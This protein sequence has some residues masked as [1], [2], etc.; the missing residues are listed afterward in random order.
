MYDG[1]AQEYV[2]LIMALV[3]E[4]HARRHVYADEWIQIP[5]SALH[6]TCWQLYQ[7][8]VPALY[9]RSNFYLSQRNN[10]HCTEYRCKSHHSWSHT[11]ASLGLSP[12]FYARF[13]TQVTLHAVL[14]TDSQSEFEL[15]SDNEELEAE[16][17]HERF[18]PFAISVANDLESLFPTLKSVHLIPDEAKERLFACMAELSGLSHQRSRAPSCV[19]CGESRYHHHV[20][21]AKAES[22]QS[23]HPAVAAILQL[24]SY[25]ARCSRDSSLPKTLYVQYSLWPNLYHHT[26]WQY[27]EHVFNI[28]LDILRQPGRR[29][30]GVAE[31][32]DALNHVN[33]AKTFSC[34]C[35]DE[36]VVA[37]DHSEVALVCMAPDV[38]TG[39]PEVV[40]QMS[41][42]D[43][44]QRPKNTGCRSCDDFKPDAMKLWNQVVGYRWSLTLA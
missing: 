31:I 44:L 43:E 26:Q 39:C 9:S 1:E 13:I 16:D 25:I 8:T 38:R 35:H 34:N 17:Y 36:H 21:L 2:D 40:E 4:Q 22:E 24:Q 37:G 29:H 12:P 23:S 19:A 18:W 3:D 6:R 28:F 42:Y 32:S 10:A 15:N 41:S 27:H 7:E 20:A 11:L 14:S 33:F 5:G 30:A